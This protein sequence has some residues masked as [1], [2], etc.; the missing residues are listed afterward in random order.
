MD[1]HDYFNSLSQGFE[2]AYA[3]ASEARSKGF[4][5]ESKV[6][7]KIAADIASR[8]EGIIGI[9]GIAEIIKGK[10]RN[11]SKPELAFEV[12]KE[13]CTNEGFSGYEP[14]KRVEL[15]VRI[16][17]AIQTDGIL[18][19]PTEG[20]YGLQQ[21]KNA[22]G[23]DYIAMVFTGP[24][25]SA[26]G[27]SVA[28]SVAF[29]DYARRMF[30][31]GSYKA[32]QEE[33]ERYV[34][35]V[36]TYNARCVRLQYK[37]AEEDL[38]SIVNNCPI[39]IDSLPTEDIE[40][41]VH[42][43]LKKTDL[44]GKEVR[45]S[46]RVRG[47]ISLVLCEG[48][49]QKA[50]KVLKEVK[51]VGLDWSWLNTV[52]KVDKG[53]KAKSGTKEGARSFLDE[54]VAGRPVLSYPGV[55]GGFRLRYGRSRMTGIAAMGMHPAT[56]ILTGGFIATGTQL[57]MEQPRK[58]CVITPVDSVEGPF[59][60]LKDGRSLRVESV[61]QANVVKEGLD[62][63]ISLGDILITFGDFK[64]ANTPLM[65][66]SYVEEF[67]EEQL[68]QKVG[69][70]AIDHETL[71]FREAYLLSLENGIP[72]HPKFLF[73]FQG[74]SGEEICDLAGFA[75]RNAK[76]TKNG[77][78][79]FSVE[80]IEFENRPELR[81]TLENLTV[82][83]CAKGESIEVYADHAQALLA[84][85]GFA[86]GK[87]GRL[88]IGEGVLEEYASYDD[89]ESL[90]IV[91]A[92][93]PFEIMQRS[94]FIAARI[95]RPE[96]AKER[97]MKPAP[98]ALFP[99]GDFGGK[100]R[101][102]TKAYI[103]DS[104]KFGSLKFKANIARYT[105]VSCKRV[106]ETPYC[107]DC[108]MSAII[109]RICDSCKNMTQSPTCERCG[110]DT[111]A[112]E[113]REIDVAKIVGSATRRLRIAKMPDIVKGVKGLSSR[114]KK[115]E[116]IEKGILRSLNGL[117]VFKDGTI[118][119]DAT[120]VPITHFY[121][122]EMNV[123]VE[124]LRSLGYDKDYLGEELERDDQLVELR[125]QDVILSKNGGIYM[126][127]TTHFID[128]LLTKF[129]GIK[130][131]YNC[132][133]A[134]DLIGH[135]VMTLSPHTSCGVLGRIIGFTDAH[136][137]FAHPYTISARRRNCDGDE[138]T[139]MMLLDG[140]VNFSRSYLPTNIG[141]TM[142]AP[143]ILSPNILPEEVDD[144]VHVVE[145]A[146]KFPL[147]FYK[148]TLERASPS[149]ASIEMVKDRLQKGE[150]RFRNLRFTHGASIGVIQSAPKKSMYSLLNNMQSKVDAEFRLMDMI[151]A[152]DKRDAAKR[153]IISHFIPDL[154]GNLHT[155]SRQGFRCVVCN[156][157]YRRI[158]LTGT[159]TRCQGKLLLTVSKGGIEKYLEIA[160]NLADAYSLEPYIRQ[161]LKLVKEE[162]GNLFGEQEVILDKR[163]F[164]LSGFM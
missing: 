86:S 117:F 62:E 137:G 41:S 3:V 82:P 139:T 142:D 65:P 129:Y 159:C 4:D 48:I 14:I 93:A 95:G 90:E 154:I 74:A 36:E 26:G 114:D 164:N 157:K 78:D 15:A 39:C 121:P 57:K 116:P 89:K 67:W 51:N 161:R 109:T 34:E 98:N 1:T 16:G 23:T 155:F 50:K 21:Y 148:K 64:N 71:G 156:A 125:H 75:A 45:V 24:I 38:R 115:V 49:A 144:E 136:V 20:V 22:D 133:T 160:I 66:S 127:K 79:L 145:V 11:Q 30:G 162:I 163:Q 83:H 81:R 18:V 55:V 7:V 100:E 147:A 54:L 47:G 61:E 118:R 105:C 131:F 35:E 40:V 124:R 110:A 42:R 92:M 111:R 77:E 146:E 2:S 94:T 6:E 9:S 72:I 143:I 106:I 120:D 134:D 103:N 96:K 52:I 29:A 122:K 17:L 13:I 10:L 87:E 99:I 140:L 135:L 85:L 130:A 25:R 97:L 88:E 70:I 132:V 53:E 69:G 84:S 152:V 141:A 158:P 113:E 60:R 31:F 19:A 33:V 8:V 104:K 108:S 151:R 102:I 44:S 128:D 138:D 27:T 150:E 101:N 28:L 76:I 153:L 46:N 73:E 43:D 68:A 63:I 12:V 32:Q 119:F 56:M 58:G 59:V 123:S 5:P 80:K 91:N 126:L 112:N 149:E 37:P 107:Y